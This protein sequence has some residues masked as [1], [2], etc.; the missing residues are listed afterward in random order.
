MQKNLNVDGYTLIVLLFVITSSI[1]Q[2][3]VDHNNASR[4][5]CESTIIAIPYP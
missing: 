4:S 2:S 1:T 3:D 5:E